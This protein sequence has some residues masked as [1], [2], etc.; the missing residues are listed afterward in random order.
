[1][2]LLRAAFVIMPP[3]VFVFVLLAQAVG[4]ASCVRLGFFIYRYI[5]IYLGFLEVSLLG[6]LECYLSLLVFLMFFFFL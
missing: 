5:Y 1:M 3:F 6:F 4:G 2:Y